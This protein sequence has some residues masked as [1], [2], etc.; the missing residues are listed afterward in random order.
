[1]A[2]AFTFYVG[3]NNPGWL[4]GKPNRHPLFV[5]VRRISKYKT[6]RPANVNWCLD[7][8]G[9]TELS[10][11]GKW[12]TSAT[13]YLEAIER[14]VD[15]SSNLQWASPQ[16]WMCEPQMIQ[17][18]GFSVETHQ[19]LTCENFCELQSL[20]PAVRIIPVLQGWHPND[21]LTH[22]EMYGAYGVDLTQHETV[23]MGSFC[24]RA[25]V[26]GVRE[27]VIELKHRNVRMHGF[28]LKKDGLR[29]FGEHLQS[30]DSMAWSLTGRI[31]G[32]KGLYLCDRVDHKAKSCGDCHT[33]AMKWA[34][35]VKGTKQRGQ[36]LLWEIAS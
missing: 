14:I 20:R 5:S 13:Q 12:Q 8:G 24:R 36:M 29:L 3:T 6:L 35:D 2:N 15:T 7:S 19:H 31:A 28:G 10:M 1:M 27:L 33:W 25:N 16:D 26:Q 30:S 9:F 22:F 18:T 17:R 11:F 23:G 21:Y 32:R 4:W 34:D